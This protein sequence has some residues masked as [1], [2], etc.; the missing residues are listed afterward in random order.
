MLPLCI[1]LWDL[2]FTLCPR[3]SAFEGLYMS[4]ATLLLS[5]VCC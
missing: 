3:T 1:V 5:H 2:Y 4:E